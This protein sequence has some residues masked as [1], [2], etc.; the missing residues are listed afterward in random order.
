[1]NRIASLVVLCASTVAHADSKAWTAAKQV[2]PANVAVVLGIDAGA[3][4]AS[5][6]YKQLVPALLDQDVEV[7]DG[8]ALIKRTCNVDAISF[9]MTGW[10]Q[11]HARQTAHLKLSDADQKRMDDATERMTKCMTKAMGY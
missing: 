8:L 4:R 6:L 11:Q 3:L 2:R 10:G 9:E 7:K 1:M 5:N